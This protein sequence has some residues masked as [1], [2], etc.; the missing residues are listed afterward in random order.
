MEAPLIST[1]GAR[2]EQFPS[3]TEDYG[4]I[5]HRVTN[6]LAKLRK[7]LKIQTKDTKNYKDKEKISTISAEN[8]EMDTRFGDVLLYLTERDLVYLEELTYGQVEFSRSTKKLVISKLKKARQSIKHLLS[9]LEN[10][11]DDLKLLEVYI[12]ACY[13]EGRLAFNRSKWTEASYSLSVGRCALQYLA[14]LQSSD[15]YT[16]IIEGYIDSELKICALK[17]E[18]DRNPDL[19]QFSKTYASK[20]TVPYLSK[21]IDIV[22][23]KDE[24]FLN[25]ISKTTLVDSVQWYE[26]SAPVGDLDLA[27]AIT[28]AQQ[29]EKSVVESDPASFDKSFL[30]WTD[31]SNSHKS[32]LKTGIDSYDEDNQDKYVIMTYIDYHQLLLRIRRNISLLKKVDVKL[33]KSKSS[34]KTSFLEN[35]KESLKLYDDVI[36]SFKELKELSGVAHNE[37]LYS[38][39]TSLQDYFIA[40]KTYK[41]AKAYLISNKYTESLAL[42][43]NVVEVTQEIKPLEEEFEGGIPSNSDLDAFKAESKTALTQVH[44]LGVYSSKQTKNS[45]SSDYLI[46]NVDQFP[47][48]SNEHILTKIADLSAGLKPVGVKPVLFD[49]A[50]NYIDYNSTTSGNAGE[51]DQ[52]KAGFFGLFGR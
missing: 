35:A 5:R 51:S 52:K 24:D 28:K 10:E 43:N 33:E 30:L 9:L 14:S 38:S 12:L 37:S 20:N 13:I 22:K 29:E 39:L 40:L 25:P 50:F 16:Q 17:L 19:L 36:S 41:I 45:V 46:D 48:L 42:L 26:F 1:F 6:R 31:A 4:R 8:Y 7:A 32:S 15:L 47:E 21:A 3:S 27:R 23:S 11:K 49:V 44:V 34:S 2:L 18:D